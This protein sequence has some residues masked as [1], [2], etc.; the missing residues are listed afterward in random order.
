[1]ASNKMGFPSRKT[2]TIKSD[3]ERDLV[4]GFE[5]Y[6]QYRVGEM[7]MVYYDPS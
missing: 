4:L 6:R 1:M 7:V 2:D 5:G 3:K